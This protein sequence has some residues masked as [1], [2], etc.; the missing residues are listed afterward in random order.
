MEFSFDAMLCSNLGKE[1]F[2]AGHI[3]VLAGRRF[4]TPVSGYTF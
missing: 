4:P 1:N 3:N 2:D